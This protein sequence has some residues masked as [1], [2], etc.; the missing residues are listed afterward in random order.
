MGQHEL[1]D[2]R[3]H[4]KRLGYI[5]STHRKKA[6]R[7]AQNVSM[8]DGV[9]YVDSAGVPGFKVTSDKEVVVMYV[10]ASW[11]PPCQVFTPML[12]DMYH[13]LIDK[14]VLE[15][16]DPDTATMPFEVVLVSVDA[17]EDDMMSYMTKYQMPW[18][19]A[20]YDDRPHLFGR[21]GEIQ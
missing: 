5:N 10:S 15:A 4:Q 12:V 2:A 18:L 1:R 14:H 20:A 7:G 6:E 16:D 17:N 21:L 13:S 11:C 19:A 3:D 9:D 8:L